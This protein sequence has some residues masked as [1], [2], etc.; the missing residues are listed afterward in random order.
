MAILLTDDFKIL[1]PLHN[2]FAHVA[3]IQNVIGIARVTSFSDV[4]GIILEPGTEHLQYLYVENC[5]DFSLTF[6]EP[7]I[8]HVTDEPHGKARI[9]GHTT[10]FF[11][12]HGSVQEW[13]PAGKKNND[14]PE[15]QRN[16]RI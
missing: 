12:W 6:A 8:S 7:S 16:Q 9:E 2:E 13:F 15:E 14:N 1:L 3:S 11:M 4:T 10:Y 5:G